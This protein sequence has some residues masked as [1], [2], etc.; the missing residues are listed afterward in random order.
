[1]TAAPP[2][3][4][5]LPL[6]Y[7]KA[8]PLHAA[9]ERRQKA[10]QQLIDLT[11]RQ[12]CGLRF[13]GAATGSGKNYCAE[14]VVSKILSQGYNPK[15]GY[16]NALPGR[17]YIVFVIP[18][19]ANRSGFAEHVANRLASDRSKT[20]NF[21]DN[22]I[23]DL[24]SN[25]DAACDY[26]AEP[27]ATTLKGAP[28]NCMFLTGDNTLDKKLRHLHDKL[29]RA[30]AELINTC[31]NAKVPVPRTARDALMQAV[32]IT[33]SELSRT[34]R[35]SRN[36]YEGNK[37]AL[38]EL[39]RL[40][41]G[42]AMSSPSKASEASILPK[43]LSLTP[44]KLWTPV[45]VLFSAPVSL[46][47][48]EFASKAVFI[49]DEFD[50]MKKDFLDM[51]VKNKLRYQPDDLVRQLHDRFCDSTSVIDH[52]LLG[53]MGSFMRLYNKA[54]DE[55]GTAA[56]RGSINRSDVGRDAKDIENWANRLADQVRKCCQ[57]QHLR[58][59]YE[60]GNDISKNESHKLFSYDDISVTDNAG[61]IEKL[62]VS[63][64]TS[65]SH[66]LITKES[67]TG[68]NQ[69]LS[70]ELNQCN[71][72]IRS[73][74]RFLNHSSRLI[75]RYFEG[76]LNR[77]FRNHE[78][79]STVVDALG[80]HNPETEQA[81]WVD[82]CRLLDT[83]KRKHRFDPAEFASVY[84]RGVGYIE[85]DNRGSHELTTYVYHNRISCLPEELLCT[86]AKHAPILA[87]SATW[88]ANDVKNWNIAYLRDVRGIV[89]NC[90]EANALAQ[91]IL[92]A[93]DDFN[94]IAAE[95]YDPQVKLLAKENPLNAL[96][97]SRAGANGNRALAE[98][99]AISYLRSLGL[100][101][102]TCGQAINALSEFIASQKQSDDLKFYITRLHMLMRTCILWADRVAA[103]EGYS[104]LVLMP[105]DLSNPDR[106]FAI[107]A[108]KLMRLC[109]DSR[110]EQGG[111]YFSRLSEKDREGC[112]TFFNSETWEDDE[113]GCAHAHKRLEKGLPTLL[114]TNIS[115]GGFSKNMQFKVPDILKSTVRH[116]DLGYPAPEGP[117]M[118]IDLI[119]VPSPTHRLITSLA[120][121]N[122]LS[123]PL[124]ESQVLLAL[125]EQS[126]LE[127]H[128]DIN[129]GA[130]LKNVRLLL[131]RRSVKDL[132]STP[133]ARVIGARIV[134]QA[135]GR[136]CRT[137]D[138]MPQPLILLEEEIATTCDF[139]WLRSHPRNLE[140]DR[141][142]STCEQACQE[143]ARD[144]SPYTPN[145]RDREQQRLNSNAQTVSRAMRD[146]H[147]N[148]LNELMKE[149]PDEK[150]LENWEAERTEILTN[151][152]NCDFD[153]LAPDDP[154]RRLMLR[155]D[156]PCEGYAYHA[157]QDFKRLECIF[158][159]EPNDTVDKLERKLI[160]YLRTNDKFSYASAR[161][162][163]LEDARF[164]EIIA[165]PEVFEHFEKCGFRTDDSS[166]GTGHMTPYQYQTVYLGALGEEAVFAILQARLAGQFILDRGDAETAERA[167]DLRVLTAEGADTG[168]WI[169]AKH[170]KMSSFLSITRDP[171]SVDDYT[172]FSCKAD[173]VGARRLIVVNLMADEACEGLR[174]KALGKD[175]RIFSVPYLIKNASIDE[176]MIEAIRTIIET[177]DR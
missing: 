106:P 36:F 98:A 4:E 125:D 176:R 12:D 153:V 100:N 5:S 6:E 166:I 62:V 41:P 109:I 117:K 92:D 52:L 103:K 13:L 141:V 39:R 144:E 139:S 58:F 2:M 90:P 174:P 78:S 146:F 164:P 175:T 94:E 110:F 34:I 57:E 65:S 59:P 86:M 128:G 114:V 10:M 47:S 171:F 55:F 154:R 111:G 19:R 40:Y 82:L 46:M 145:P 142:I 84:S 56:S 43:V 66:K 3:Q 115:A 134:A 93:S 119:F 120:D 64:S 38:T 25:A 167:G 89:I 173:K 97:H 127:V 48:P 69:T 157:E 37:M 11:L 67:M 20:N 26:F 15:T 138:K 165:I 83:G 96:A 14:Q 124:D 63:K 161:S 80:F 1:M 24:K 122:D 158:P 105:N 118:D 68:G 30:C 77:T 132:L 126:E 81:A 152:F 99:K 27:N 130:R 22:V 168:I 137:N 44:Q 136:I 49:M 108:R 29:F 112:I 102:Y 121:K 32:S 45:N 71:M 42:S 60:L 172:R 88:A 35:E 116:L 28:P 87:M 9:H 151:P 123:A 113:Y 135:V 76:S 155:I 129:A 101:E 169:D 95:A 33:Y 133:S 177:P 148:L 143:I 51:E 72:I 147:H 73:A 163:T 54:A 23:L 50:H 16:L 160:S 149:N 61:H 17:K 104:G 170:W 75:S 21:T 53:D 156:T 85:L 91:E 18:G 159:V 79:L 131:N 31:R 7:P 107:C 140:L 150:A 74:A 70:H 8:S 162:V